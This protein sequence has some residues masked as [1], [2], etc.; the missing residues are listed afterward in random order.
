MSLAKM[1]RE[2]MAH[3]LRGR[4]AGCVM[5]VAAIAVPAISASANI[6]AITDSNSSATID[7]SSAAGMFNW[8]I[9]GVN[10]L[11]QQWF[12]YR[13][14]NAGPER[15]IDTLVQTNIAN[16]GNV[17]SV[18]YKD[19]LLNPNFSIT[20][21]L[22]LNG[23]GAGSGSADMIEDLTIRN[24]T[25]QEQSFHFYQYADFDLNGSPTDSLVQAQGSPIN[26]VSQSEN[27]ASL[28]EVVINSNVAP[29]SHHQV[30]FFNSILNL[31]N[32]A[33]PDNLTD[34]SGPLGPG[35]LTWA[36]QWD[37]QLA[38]NSKFDISKDIR[39]Q[40]IPAPAAPALLALAG[41]MTF[42]RRR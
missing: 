10:Q 32:N 28:Q 14:G 30:D 37:F 11:F 7:T 13:V 24:L 6:V 5:A 22:T 1:F 26:T 35:D 3:V 31:L 8:Q 39:I 25:N 27:G 17:M 18:E 2:K 21:T 40:A 19:A 15:S 4:L 29:I 20:V 12:W 36:L 42:R 23:G 41:L 34:T 33:N 38:A 16:V 9:D